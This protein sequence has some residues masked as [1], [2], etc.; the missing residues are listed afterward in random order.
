MLTALTNLSGVARGSLSFAAQQSQRPV[1]EAA[2]H[3]VSPTLP[4]RLIV[5]PAQA[6]IQRQAKPSRMLDDSGDYAVIRREGSL[7]LAECSR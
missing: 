7:L 6:G 2:P 3:D 5:I 4:S 1:S